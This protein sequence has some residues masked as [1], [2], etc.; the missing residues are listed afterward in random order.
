MTAVPLF[1]SPRTRRYDL[2][3]ISTGPESVGIEVRQTV[4]DDTETVA[5]VKPEEITR[6]L[7]TINSALRDSGHKPTVLSVTRRKPIPL[8]EAAGVRLALGI[9]AAAPLRRSNRAHAVLNGISAMS[10][11]ETYYWHAKTSQ[12]ES[13]ARALRALRI[14]L[15]DDHRTGV[16]A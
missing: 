12:P 15:A 1:S 2:V 11:E 14:L 3:V 10:D 13:G 4:G 8:A 9:H 6:Y 7:P 5:S 16:T